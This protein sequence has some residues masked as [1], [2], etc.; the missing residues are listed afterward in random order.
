[1]ENVKAISE[2]RK[3]NL[4]GESIN[5]ITERLTEVVHKVIAKKAKIAMPTLYRTWDEF[6][7]EFCKNGGIIE[8]VPFCPHNLVASPSISFFI[9]PD[10]S[11]NV[12][13]SFDRFSATE[14]INAGCFFP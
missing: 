14:Y 12:V 4:S 5:E 6:M 13:G 1:M 11:I 9:E 7:N 10:G 3:K 8:A 2:L